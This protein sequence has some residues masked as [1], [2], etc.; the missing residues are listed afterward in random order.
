MKR[1]LPV[2]GLLLVLAA[3]L[4]VGRGPASRTPAAR[5]ERI[6]SGIKCPTCQGLS[7]AQ[8]KAGP[9]RAIY[10]EIVREVNAGSSDDD[11]RAYLVS[12]YGLSQLLRPEATGEG[13]IVWIVPIALT[14]VAFAS[15]AFAFRRWR[16]TGAVATADDRALVDRARGR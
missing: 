4:A 3:S 10:A 15:I 14:I 9:A 7:V 11:V 1:W 2:I 5:A 13:S 6:A 8:S 16:P 12:R